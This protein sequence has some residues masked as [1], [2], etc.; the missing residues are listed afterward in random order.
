MST[1]QVL[2]SATA[3]KQQL[4][5]GWKR[6]EIIM[7]EYKDMFMNQY[8][9]S[10]RERYRHSPKQPRVKAHDRP[11]LGDIVQLKG[12]SKNRLNW[13]VGQI[14]ELVKGA[15]GQCRVAKVK[16][17]NTIFN[18]SIGHLYP[19]E[20][21]ETERPG[22]LSCNNIE[23]ETSSRLCNSNIEENMDAPVEM[24]GEEV[25]DLQ[26]EADVMDVIDA[27][28]DMTQTMKETIESTDKTNENM[29]VT[30][31]NDNMEQS[32]EGNQK[33]V[34]AVRAL[35]KIREWTSHLMTTLTL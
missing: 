18:R 10:L 15:D 8:L 23:P 2:P 14:V 27:N 26:P 17:G 16:I 35:E 3:T 11:S 21:D 28:T 19:L 20:I 29:D 32:I 31:D 9:L 7:N 33:R 30:D 1:S 5:E 13:K 24:I 25:T 4:I 34:A 22:N 12:E 6:G